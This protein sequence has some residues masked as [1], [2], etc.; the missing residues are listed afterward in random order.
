[1]L[2][3]AHRELFGADRR[4]LPLAPGAMV[5]PGFA[6]SWE[7]PLLDGVRAVVEAA[8]FRHMLTPGGRR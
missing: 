5:L 6:L 3:E 7:G 2:D 8:P 1:M 4:D